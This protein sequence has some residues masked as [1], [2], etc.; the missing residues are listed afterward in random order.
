MLWM[1]EKFYEKPTI[2][3]F[4]WWPTTHNFTQM[5]MMMMMTVFY[6]PFNII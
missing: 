4:A 1:N 3:Q 5:M 2:F 6:F